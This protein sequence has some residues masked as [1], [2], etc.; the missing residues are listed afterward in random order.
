MKPNHTA[1][2]L[3]QKVFNLC[4]ERGFLFPSY[5]SHGGMRGS[6]DYGPLG[7]A[8]KQNIIAAWQEDVLHR[9]NLRPNPLRLSPTTEASLHLEDNAQTRRKRLLDQL[10]V[11]IVQYDSSIF[12]PRRVF[13]ASGHLDNFTDTLVDCR[14]SQ[15]RFRADKA[16]VLVLVPVSETT[17]ESSLSKYAL[18]IQAT[19]KKQAKQWKDQIEASICPGA[20][21]ERRGKS[22]YLFV[23]DVQCSTNGQ[24][25][26]QEDIHT[27]LSDSNAS[28]DLH[29]ESTD[30]AS[31]PRV[32]YRGY[33][34]PDSNSPFLS[35]A[36]PF[37]LMLKTFSGS[38]DPVQQVH[39]GLSSCLESSGS[40]GDTLTLS[41]DS[42][43]QW[44]DTLRSTPQLMLRPETA[45][46]I[47]ANYQHI[48]LSNGLSPPFGVAQVGKAFRN[49]FNV[50][51]AIFR[52]V[53]F[54]Q[55]ELELFVPADATPELWFEPVRDARMRW[56]QR[57][58]NSKDHVRFHSH[59]KE[60]LAHYARRCD[61]I[62]YLFPWGWSEVEGVADRGDYDLR[63][64]ARGALSSSP[65]DTEAASDSTF[66]HIIEASAGVNRALLAFLMDAYREVTTTKGDVRPVLALHPRLA[67][68]KVAVM[69]VALT[70]AMVQKSIEVYDHFRYHR[71]PCYYERRLGLQV[72]KRYF[73][74]DQL[75]TP[76]YVAVD[77]VTLEDGTVTVR[78]RD[79][80]AQTRV[81]IG[82]LIG[83]IRERIQ[84]N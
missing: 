47:F 39:D 62:E 45:Q 82:D 18:K 3:F 26:L 44:L 51:Y 33:V 21:V 7:I 15:R 22:V 57:Y 69:P 78:D 54:E 10:P 59:A 37:S 28:F 17:F 50:E 74:Q 36:R 6:Y 1:N 68:I 84:E 31:S 75:G 46:G 24:S 77:E 27:L 2:L 71:I 42:A 12:G 83:Y 55:M 32:A 65:V 13:K 56:W 4:K 34:E 11:P 58:L 19:D 16:A 35:E 66:P 64:H 41:R 14:L 25:L 60:A 67:P 20:R 30:A 52:S 76:F 8:L 48:C 80:A 53:E 49:E 38:V 79:T 29:F 5:H 72:G 23:A 61:D 9:M 73:R 63:A 40:E 70:D 81:S 43:N